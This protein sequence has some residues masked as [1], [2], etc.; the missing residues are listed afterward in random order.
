MPISEAHLVYDPETESIRTIAEGG[1]IPGA[2]TGARIPLAT[3]AL[4][5]EPERWRLHEWPSVPQ[6]DDPVATR[7]EA[8]RYLLRRRIFAIVPGGLANPDALKP[9]GPKNGYAKFLEP[10]H[11]E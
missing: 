5:L 4:P 9:C 11:L 7:E 6:Q 2:K 8:E 10:Q 3:R 1:N